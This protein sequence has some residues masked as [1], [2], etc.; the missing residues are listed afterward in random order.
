MMANKSP[1]EG[2]ITEEGLRKLREMKGTKLRQTL[3]ARGIPV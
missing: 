1:K 3:Q 2:R